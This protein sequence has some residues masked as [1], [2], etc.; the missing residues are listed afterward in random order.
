M[1][2]S[3]TRSKRSKGKNIVNDVDPLQRTLRSVEDVLDQRRFFSRHDQMV[4]YG[5]DFYIRR[6]VEP[7]IMNFQ[8]FETPGLYFHHHLMFKASP[9][10]FL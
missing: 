2:S 5:R 9:T 8:S 7:K 1:A 4:N 6:V 10:L 3:S